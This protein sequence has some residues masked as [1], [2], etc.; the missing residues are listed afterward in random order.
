MDFE[1]VIFDFDGTVGDTGPGVRNAVRYALNKYEMPIYEDRLNEFLGPPLYL[2]FENMYGVTPEFAS[3]LVDTY[4]VYYK[5]TGVY[6]VEAYPGIIEIIE[7]LKAKGVKLAVASSKPQKFLDICA[8]HIGVYDLFDEIVGPELENHQANKTWLVN[9]ACERLNIEPSKK[10]AMIGDRFYD[11]EGA[12]TAGV[13]SIGV[14]YG[15]GNRAEF[16]EYGADIIAEKVL[17]LKTILL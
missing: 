7:E 5:D 17:D 8:K 11:I 2:T 16:E 3:E 14:E 9:R 6:E 1:A 10:V 15:F 4:R 13:T 12:N